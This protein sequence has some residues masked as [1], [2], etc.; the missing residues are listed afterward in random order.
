MSDITSSQ[1]SKLSLNL[2][3]KLDNKIKKSNGIYFTPL[4]IIK[5]TV[6][7]ILS[8]KNIDINTVLM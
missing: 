8:L 3:S 5:K 4:D 2:T 1:Y 6:D 7:F